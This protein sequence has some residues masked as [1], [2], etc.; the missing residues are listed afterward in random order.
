LSDKNKNNAEWI[1]PT[2]VEGPS[3]EFYKVEAGKTARAFLLD[4]PVFARVHFITGTGFVRTLSEY[5]DETG[6]RLTDGVDIELMGKEP[7]VV[8]M[9]PIVVFDTDS[10]GSIGSRKPANVPFKIYLWSYYKSTQQ[11]IFDLVSEWGPE[12]E[13]KDLL[14]AGVKSGRYVNTDVQV[15]AKNTLTQ[16]PGLKEAIEQARGVY[17]YKDI[18]R[19]IARTLTEDEFRQAL[20]VADAPATQSPPASAASKIKK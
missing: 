19:W 2:K 8:Y 10:K 9:A 14:I 18:E 20:N 15:A 17:Q 3:K 6:K 1:D 16:A 11:Q 7:Q 5:D 12:F 4:R 13:T